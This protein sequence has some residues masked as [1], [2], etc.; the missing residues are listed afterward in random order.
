MKI[1]VLILS[2]LGVVGGA[3][4]AIIWLRQAVS[5]DARIKIWEQRELISNSPQS[6]SSRMRRQ[7]EAVVFS[8]YAIIAAVSVGLLAAVLFAA[9]KIHPLITG[10]ILVCSSVA[11]GV[12]EPRGLVFSS[13][14]LLAGGVCF[15]MKLPSG[16]KA[17]VLA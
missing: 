7:Y 14:M 16:K 4:I 1:V 11:A 6:Q 8:A 17:A 13:P 2:L 15:L 12:L 9:G 10:V 3:G 5:E